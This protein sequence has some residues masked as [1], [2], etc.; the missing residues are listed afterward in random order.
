MSFDNLCKLLA[1]KHPSSFA[2]WQSDP[3]IPLRMLDYWVRLHRLYRLPV[4]QVVILL[5]PPPDETVIET[6]FAVETT[7]HQYQVVKMWLEEP[8]RFLADVALLPLATLTRT[9]HPEELL[10]RVADRID[11]IVNRE[12]KTEVAAYVQLI[13]GLKYDRN[14]IRQIFQEEIMRDSVIYQEI[15][16][17]GEDRGLQQGERAII[18]RQLS[19][20]LGQLNPEL[21]TKIE[22]L[23]LEKLENLAEELLNFT[24]ISELVSWLEIN[25]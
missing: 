13:A 15:F 22:R 2:T 19:K 5:L 24:S 7:T 1:E 4:T 25:Q 23:S 16:Q 21:T 10:S 6:V 17:R 8:D 12:E 14:K 3:P 20:K 9:E 18:L 11:E